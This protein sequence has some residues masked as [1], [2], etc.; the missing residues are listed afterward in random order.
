MKR[1]KAE[2]E[3]SLPFSKKSDAEALRRALGPE[4]VA[5][6]TSRASVRVIRRKRVLAMRF[7]AKDLVA[8]R[9]MLNS[10]LR[11]AATWRRVSEALDG[12]DEDRAS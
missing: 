10:Y 12:Q 6:K 2:A 11:M 8:L 7:F 4:T 3:I 5:P 1:P 9:A